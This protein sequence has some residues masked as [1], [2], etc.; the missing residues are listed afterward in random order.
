MM[1]TDDQNEWDKWFS[2]DV[3]TGDLNNPDFD[4]SNFTGGYNSGPAPA[5]PFNPG[6]LA[7]ELAPAT[8]PQ[9][10]ADL[11]FTP[12]LFPSPN[13]STYGPPGGSRKQ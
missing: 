5:P 2:P 4:F 7:S 11:R 1:L 9:G 3:N 12:T 8:M 13:Y 10:M 6:A